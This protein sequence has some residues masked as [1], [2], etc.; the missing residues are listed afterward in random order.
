MLSV[1]L[2]FVIGHAARIL[3]PE[4]RHSLRELPSP[5]RHE[6]RRMA[7]VVRVPCFGRRRRY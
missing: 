1:P 5:L 4:I 3:A 7:R 6:L 2:A